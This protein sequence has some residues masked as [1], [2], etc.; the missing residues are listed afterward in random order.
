MSRRAR[1]N[2]VVLLV[3]AARAVERKSADG[4]ETKG[5]D[6]AKEGED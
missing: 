4:R 5:E 3:E 6:I 1:K 2:E